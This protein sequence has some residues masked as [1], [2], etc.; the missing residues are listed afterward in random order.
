MV[1]QQVIYAFTLW[2]SFLRK[3]YPWH[4][5][6]QKYSSTEVF[7]TE[8]GLS[9]SPSGVDNLHVTVPYRLQLPCIFC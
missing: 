8:S 5:D 2:T 3:Q 6:C 9:A 4:R 1:F 7:I